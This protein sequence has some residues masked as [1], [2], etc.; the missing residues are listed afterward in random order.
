M[1][2]A[3]GN[4]PILTRLQTAGIQ[5][6]QSGIRLFSVIRNEER[7]IPFFL[8]YYRDKG[9]DEFFFV[10]NGS[11]DAS[12]AILSTN[13]RVNLFHTSEDFADSRCGIRWLEPLL[14]EYGEHRWCVVADA[15][16]LLTYPHCEVLSLYQL[17]EYLDQEGASAMYCIL[18]DMYSQEPFEKTTYRAGEDPRLIA[19]FYEIDSIS[20]TGSFREVR[21][22]IWSHFGGPR[23]RLFGVEV[24]LDKIGIFKY[25][26]KM[27]LLGGMHRVYG[28]RLSKARGAMLHFKYFDDF[29]SR[30][31][32]EAGRGQHWNNAVQ[33]K[34]YAAVLEQC[35]QLRAYAT[36]SRRL[37]CSQD[38]IN[39]GIMCCPDEL[40]SYINHIGKNITS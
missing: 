2:T 22:G 8:E 11:T 13:K 31:V 29:R 37:T 35:D 7:R 12:A 24:S 27:S 14:A 16:E 26:L 10:D 15:D 33:Y 40:A 4:R 18:L 36:F 5:A 9:V 21:A 34:Q 39:C 6:R 38:L 28:A 1:S 19:P 17:C 3:S 30:T 23:R 25:D 20:C 32:L